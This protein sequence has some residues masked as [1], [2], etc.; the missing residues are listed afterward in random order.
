VDE[1]NMDQDISVLTVLGIDG[2]SVEKPKDY[3][4]LFYDTRTAGS[5]T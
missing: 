2:F 4:K 1:T 3:V 5:Y